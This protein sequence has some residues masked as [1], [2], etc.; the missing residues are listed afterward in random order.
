MKTGYFIMKMWKM[1]NAG[2]HNIKKIDSNP[3]GGYVSYDIA[4]ENLEGLYHSGDW[5]VKEG[6]YTF[7]IMELFW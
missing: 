4:K 2:S 3:R 1:G 5:E 6:G 7:A